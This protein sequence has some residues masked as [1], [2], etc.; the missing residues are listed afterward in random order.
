MAVVLTLPEQQFT[1]AG[2]VAADGRVRL[3]P[4]AGFE[5]FDMRGR[6]NGNGTVLTGTFAETVDGH[7]GDVFG[8]LRFVAR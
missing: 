7:L 2:M 1:G 6:F 4:C 5:C 3:L 8:D